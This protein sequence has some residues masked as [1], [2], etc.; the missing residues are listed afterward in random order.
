MAATWTSPLT[1]LAWLEATARLHGPIGNTEW[2]GHTN[3]AFVGIAATVWG[4]PSGWYH[5][6]GTHA[7][8]DPGVIPPQDTWTSFGGSVWIDEPAPVGLPVDEFAR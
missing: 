3:A 4:T 8:F 5:A 2:I 1:A 6:T 7:Y